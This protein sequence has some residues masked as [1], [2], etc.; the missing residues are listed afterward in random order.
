M[1]MEPAEARNLGLPGGYD[2]AGILGVEVHWL[3]QGLSCV[4]QGSGQAGKPLARFSGSCGPQ[5]PGSLYKPAA[6]P[7]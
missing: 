3:G 2:L 5:P 4:L 6:S 7:L 1:G